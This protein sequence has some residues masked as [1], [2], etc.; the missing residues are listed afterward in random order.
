[1]NQPLESTETQIEVIETNAERLMAIA[2][3]GYSE[4]KEKG[5]VIVLRQLENDNARLEDWQIIFKPMSILGNM[6]S[7]WK[8]SGLQDLIVKYNPELS[9]IC[10]FLYPNGSHRSYHF[11][12]R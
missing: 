11:G 10:T 8:E 2:Q 5:T 3:R 1:M 12:D 6:V 7:D 4:F 9:A